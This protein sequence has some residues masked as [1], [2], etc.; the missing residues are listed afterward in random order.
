MSARLAGEDR[1]RF[2]RRHVAVRERHGRR[3][4]HGATASNAAFSLAVTLLSGTGVRAQVPPDRTDPTTIADVTSATR[5]YFRQPALHGDLVV[6]VA[7]G[8]LWR[9]PAAGGLAQ[10]LTSHTAEETRPAISPDGRWL[11]FSASYEGPR[12]VWLMPVTGGPPI[13][14]TW[15]GA[16]A[17]VAGWAPDGR[18]LYATQKYS[19][20]PNTQLVTLSPCYAERGTPGRAATNE[21]SA[22]TCSPQREVLPLATGAEGSW[23]ADGSTLFFNRFAKQG[24]FTKRYVGGT[25]ENIWRWQVGTD[26]EATALTADWPGTSRSP[27][28]WNGRVYFA[29]DRAPKGSAWPQGERAP[30][31]DGGIM[32]VWSMDERGGDVRQHTFHSDYD[33]QALS[34]HDGRI[35]YQQGAD[36]WLLDLRAPAT[37][38]QSTANPARI[39][40]AL[41]SDFDQMRENWIE[42]PM[43]YLTAAH[44]SPNGDRI[45]LV[46]RGHVFVAPVGAGRLVHVTRKPGVRYRQAK[47]LADG[48]RLLALSDESAEVELW[49]LP[50]DGL[51]EREQ[52]THDATILRWDG[53][54]SPDGRWIAHSDKNQ[55]LW[56]YDTREERDRK[57]AHSLHAS[58]WI[59]SAPGF[60]DL[61]W[62]PDSRW[63][64]YNDVSTNFL[65]RIV[66]YDT[67]TGTHT[68]VTTDR[69]DSWSP[70]WS[71]DGN[72][73]WFLSDRT[74][75]SRVGSPWGARQPD[76]YF[77]ER[78]RIYG[79]SLRQQFDSPF[80]AKTELASSAAAERPAPEASPGNAVPPVSAVTIDLTGITSRLIEVPVPAGNHRDL[81]TDGRRLYWMNVTSATP[82][83]TNLISVAI[84]S[85]EATPAAVV[86]NIVAFELSADRRKLMVRRGQDIFVF[87]A[88]ARAPQNLNENRVDLGGW[89]FPV[90]PREEWQHHFVDAWR[91]E[92]DYFYDT[93]M[94]GVDWPAMLRKYQPL[95]D[96]VTDRSELNDVIAQMVGELSA[97][98]IYVRGGDLR[99]AAEEAAVPGLGGVLERDE[100]ARGWRVARIYRS[101]PDLPDD[102]APLAR[103]GVDV[104]EGDVILAIDG[105]ATLDVADPAV[106]LRN[107]A[108]RQVRITVQPA[109]RGQEQRDV[110]VEPITQGRERELR[111][112][113]WEYTRR[114]A[115]DSLSEG[116]IGYVHLRAMGS[117]NIAEWTREYY[118]VFNRHGLIIDVRHNSGGNI[119]SWLLGKLLRQTWFWWQPRVGEPYGNM[120]YAFNGPM[121]VLVNERTASDGEAFAE[122]FRRL[123]LGRVIGNRTWGG[124]IWL[125]SNNVLADRGIATAAE[126]GVYAD[127]EWLIEGWGVDP[128]VAIENTPLA[129]AGG[130]DAQLEAAVRALLDELATR[131]VM[132]P[133][134][135][136]YPDKGRR[137]GGG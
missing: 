95:A 89:S 60:A 130:R 35:A 121:V 39:A 45:A 124:E 115:V 91:L 82:R 116:R 71:P 52:L 132:T 102:L 133:P 114:L 37:N 62:S 127:G 100:A 40:I 66:I 65:G 85:T 99:T 128:D 120:P 49:T 122:G 50:A 136:A 103:P 36:L 47:F 5:G 74:F 118:P 15:D 112:D 104:R 92:R 21:T 57:I 98:H 16:S 48:K 64:A 109:A 90:D 79:I 12:E 96:R 53:V 76:P 106:L 80:A 67:Q 111:Y 38:G 25:A 8:D 28:W 20:L 88:A 137:S 59:S 131:P 75:N 126:Q 10:R 86:E 51:G 23:S 58:A 119:D 31:W 113:E 30:H 3:R 14:Q 27:L 73:L 11:A 9:V 78:T 87:D 93:A 72:W 129:T 70:A 33:V 17:D 63:L 125:S 7:E 34:L 84:G 97:L 81:A 13:R 54:P 43:E 94:H 2:V 56:L 107:K 105:V 42:R 55:D 134:P 77:D 108:G 22:P 26:R 4:R 1:R 69:Y 19:T 83:R 6:F 101:D 135:P 110:I 44:V 29:S 32:N 117:G 123:G 68:P 61:A 18:L 24:S 46:S 41:A